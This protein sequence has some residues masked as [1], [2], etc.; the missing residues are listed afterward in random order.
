[1]SISPTINEQLLHLQITKAQKDTDDVSVF[2]AYLGSVG[3]RAA[4]QMII[5]LT[6]GVNFTNNLLPVFLEERFF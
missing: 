4:R 1:V 2:F 6:Q 5:K 3:L